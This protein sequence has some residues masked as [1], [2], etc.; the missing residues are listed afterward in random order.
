MVRLALKRVVRWGVNKSI[1]ILNMMFGMVFNLGVFYAGVL[2]MRY[3]IL[4][5]FIFSIGGPMLLYYIMLVL[6]S[7]RFTFSFR[8]KNLFNKIWVFSS[9]EVVGGLFKGCNSGN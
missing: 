1:I 4:F 3:L 6:M 2:L 9:G 8:G 5:F 7:L